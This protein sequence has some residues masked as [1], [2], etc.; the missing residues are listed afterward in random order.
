MARSGEWWV[1]SAQ[2]F[3]DEGQAWQQLL[4]HI[5]AFSEHLSPTIASDWVAQTSV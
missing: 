2:M 1:K 3:P 4:S 5:L